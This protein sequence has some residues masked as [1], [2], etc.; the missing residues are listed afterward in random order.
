MKIESNIPLP[1]TLSIKIDKGIAIPKLT[2]TLELQIYTASARAKYYMQ[3]GP[4]KL[5]KEMDNWH[6]KEAYVNAREAAHYA[7]VLL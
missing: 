3:L 5:G 1:N 4:H 2:S 7:T 6:I